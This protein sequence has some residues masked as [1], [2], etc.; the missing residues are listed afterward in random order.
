MTSGH[1]LDIQNLRVQFT[2]RRG[3]VTAVHD[4]SFTLDPGE[5]LCLIGESGSGKS[6]TGLAITGLL[7]KE[8]V[9]S[10]S[11]L[12]NG[13]NLLD[14]GD[15]QM[16]RIRGKE[17]AMVFQD[18]MSALD[19]VHTIGKQIVET[20]MAHEDIT[21][22]AAWDASVEMLGLVGIPDPKQRMLSY[23][24]ELSG[25]MKQRAVIAIA[26]ICRPRLL[27]ADEPTTALDVTIQAQ[28]IELL[29]ALQSRLGMALLFVTHDLGVV[30]E[31]ADKVVVVYGGRVVE[32]A[33]AASI[34]ESPRMPYTRAL[35]DLAPHFDRPRPRGERLPAIPGSVPD[36]SVQLSGCAFAPRCSEA[37]S[38]CTEIAPSLEE[39][40]AR[41][42]VRC[43]RWRDLAPFPRREL[44]A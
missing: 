42:L 30:A 40:S 5:T 19:P 36:P 39:A 44:G 18:A 22:R 34:Y 7:P 43:L 17:I 24:H 15:R 1:L 21:Y 37:E 12:F 2:T 32:A 6:V 26:L 4:M 38:R 31:I 9:C 41:H 28:I 8:R 23:P 11:V 20:L 10:G 13:R 27:I 25:G 14:L 35:I 3:V 33:K 29:R 16:R